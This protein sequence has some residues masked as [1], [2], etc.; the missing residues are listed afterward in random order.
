MSFSLSNTHM[1]STEALRLDGTWY[2]DM[3]QKAKQECV[4]INFSPWGQRGDWMCVCVCQGRQLRAV[5]G[6][7]VMQ[8]DGGHKHSAVCW[9]GPLSDSPPRQSLCVMEWSFSVCLSNYPICLC[10]SVFWYVYL[11]AWV[12][13]SLPLLRP[14]FFCLYLDLYFELEKDLSIPEWMCVCL[15]YV[16]AGNTF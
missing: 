11:T 8:T 14:L 5:S 3:W 2:A 9:I 10:L 15:L 4:Y 12:C 6:T 13:L 16:C 1:Y 7:L